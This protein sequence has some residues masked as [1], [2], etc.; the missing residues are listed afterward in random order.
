MFF[1]EEGEGMKN[2]GNLKVTTEQCNIF[3]G[4][5]MSFLNYR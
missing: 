3:Y 1:E 5:S 4:K 2:Q